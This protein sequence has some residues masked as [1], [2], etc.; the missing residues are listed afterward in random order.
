MTKSHVSATETLYWREN[1]ETPT[2]RKTTPTTL[3]TTTTT[4]LTAAVMSTRTI[5]NSSWSSWQSPNF[6]TSSRLPTLPLCWLVLVLRLS[7][8]ICFTDCGSAA[9]SQLLLFYCWFSV[10]CNDFKT[11]AL[12]LLTCGIGRG[13]RAS[14][15][16]LQCYNYLKR[17]L[18]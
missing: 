1:G 6:R 14:A 3:A 8:L 5:W 4:P 17:K 13:S 9:G 16:C 2:R 11:P 12:Y 7:A 18:W 10:N 15:I